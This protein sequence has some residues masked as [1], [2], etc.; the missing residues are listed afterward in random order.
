MNETSRANLRRYQRRMFIVFSIYTVLIFGINYLDD[1]VSL[2]SWQRIGL[3]F[4][5]VLPAIATVFIVLE[6]VRTLDEVWQRIITEAALI[7]AGVVGLGTFTLGFMEGVIDLPEGILIWIWPAMIA[8]QG[9]AMWVVRM[10]Y[11]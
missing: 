3:S 5:P 7:S 4:L 10:R 8:I 9:I 11:N 6:F 2:A 1:S